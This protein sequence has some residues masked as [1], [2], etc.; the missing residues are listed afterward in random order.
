N[1]PTFTPGAPYEVIVDDGD[2]WYSDGGN[3][4]YTNDGNAESYNGDYL[5]KSTTETETNWAKWQP[6]LNGTNYDVY[7]RYRAGSNRVTDARYTVTFAGGATQSIAVDQTVN[8]GVWV[9]IGTFRFD[10]GVNGSV[11]LS[12]QSSQV[13]GRVVIAD[14]VRFVLTPP[15]TRTIDD[16]DAGFSLN[17]AWT[18]VTNGGLEPI[19]GDYYYAST[20]SSETKSAIW[21]PDLV[22]DGYYRVSV[23]YRQGANRSNQ[24][25]Y[26]VYYNGGWQTISVNQQVNGGTWFVLGTWHFKSGTSGYV[27]LGNGPAPTGKIVL[28]DAV[29]FEPQ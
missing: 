20:A 1:T 7:V 14:A 6:Y 4:G 8:G 16:G 2:V 12:N 24:A 25:P 17:G 13:G 27:K 28:A 5:W 23:R 19:N 10:T 9:F 21:R 29:L 26:T 18:Y 11:V 15:V 22:Q 3:W